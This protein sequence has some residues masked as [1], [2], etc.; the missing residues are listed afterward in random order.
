M[1]IPL[2]ERYGLRSDN[3]ILDPVKDTDCFALIGPDP[4]E[5]AEGLDTDLV[6]GLAPKRMFW[7][8]YGGGKTHTLMRTM[9][10]LEKLTPI[11]AVRVECPDLAKKSRFHDLYREGIMRALGEDLVIGLIDDAVRSVGMARRE[12]LTEKLRDRFQDEEVAK[13]AIRLIDP[14]FD[15]LRLWRWISG[16]PLSRADLDD[17]GQT[18]DLTQTEAARLADLLAL[19]GRLMQEFRSKKLVLVLDEMERLFQIGQETIT[20]FVS[21][22]SR[23]VDPTQ[24]EVCVLIGASAILQSELVEIFSENSPVVSRLTGENIREV[25]YMHDEDLDRLIEAVITYRRSD[26]ADIQS[27]VTNAQAVTGETI[28]VRFFPF[29]TPAVE[30]LKSRLTNAMTPR[31][32]TMQMTRA[33]GRAYRGDAPVI[34]TQFAN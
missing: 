3:F 14:N 1:P 25:S 18:Q 30:A 29:T 34:T 13:A 15:S 9:R 12:E 17:L 2:S 21:G 23:L 27:L 5:I 20:T 7:G 32:I 28:E 10:E 16:V 26:A 24:A 19:V 11:H 31:E 22:F 6:T 8:P 33:L 4:T